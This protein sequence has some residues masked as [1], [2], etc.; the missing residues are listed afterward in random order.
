MKI[1]WGR[2]EMWRGRVG[3]A[4]PLPAFS[5]VGA[6]V[7][8]PCSV[9]HISLFSCSKRFAGGRSQAPSV[10]ICGGEGSMPHYQH[11]KR[12]N[13]KGPNFVAIRLLFLRKYT[14]ALALRVTAAVDEVYCSRC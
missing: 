1:R 4:Y 13:K 12:A 8:A 5:S 2:V 6:S 3:A 11:S 14:P 7:G 9:F 10:T